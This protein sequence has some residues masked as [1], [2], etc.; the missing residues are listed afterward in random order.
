LSPGANWLAL[1]YGSQPWNTND[2][3][4]TSAGNPEIRAVLWRNS[5]I[6]DLGTL[7]GTASLAGGTFAGVTRALLCS[8]LATAVRPTGFRSIRRQQNQT[9]TMRPWYARFA[10]CAADQPLQ[11][12]GRRFESASTHQIK[13]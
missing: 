13:L 9:V 2:Q 11:D 3:F 8:T 5:K 10:A 12:E 6:Q 7:G 4:D 1:H